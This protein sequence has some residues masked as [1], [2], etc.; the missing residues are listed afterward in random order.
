M[1]VVYTFVFSVVF[2][3]KW[4]EGSTSRTSFALVLFS[5]LIIFNLFSECINKAPATILA[6]SNYVKSNI[7]VGNITMD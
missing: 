1:L 6:N 3:A 4:S 2:Q 5:G 7:S